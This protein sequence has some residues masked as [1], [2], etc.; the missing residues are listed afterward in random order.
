MSGPSNLARAR[1]H[2]IFIIG[3][4]A[5]AAYIL[6]V[7]RG[8]GVLSE[9]PRAS[10]SGAASGSTGQELLARGDGWHAVIGTFSSAEEAGRDWDAIR[11][12]LS[13]FGAIG[14][15]LTPADD[16]IRLQVGPVSSRHLG[17]RLCTVIQAA[18]KSCT[19]VQPSS[20]QP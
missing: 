15:H 18:G 10:Q 12:R 19:L 7:E 1:S 3:L 11:G 14:V 20:A 6:W 13:D 9:A 8:R 5:A 16:R 17:E 2:I 4:L